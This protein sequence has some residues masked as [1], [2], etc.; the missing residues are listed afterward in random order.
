MYLSLNR[1]G[2]RCIG[3]IEYDGSIYNEQGIDPRD[4]EEYKLV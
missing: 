1:H 3:V 4:L 2:A